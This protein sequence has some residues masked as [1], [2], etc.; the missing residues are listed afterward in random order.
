MP[1]LAVCLHIMP[2]HAFR[3]N[4]YV[5]AEKL[6][7]AIKYIMFRLQARGKRNCVCRCYVNF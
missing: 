4:I 2:P 3:S 7:A 5:K 1:T 6:T